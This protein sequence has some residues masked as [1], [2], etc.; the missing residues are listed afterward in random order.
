MD[1]AS[2]G[3]NDALRDFVAAGLSGPVVGAALARFRL[4]WLDGAVRTRDEG[5]A[6]A[7][8]LAARAARRASAKPR[9]KGAATRSAATKSRRASLPAP[10]PSSILPPASPPTRALHPERR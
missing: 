2:G 3:G 7:R 8:E 4:A 10:E 5:V 9:K 1:E 6:L